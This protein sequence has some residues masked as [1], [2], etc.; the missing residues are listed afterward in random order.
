MSTTKHW[1]PEILKDKRVKY[2]LLILLWALIAFLLLLITKG[3]LG[4]H[5]KFLG[6]EV[7]A[8]NKIV[9]ADTGYFKIKDTVYTPTANDGRII[10]TPKSTKSK[11]AQSSKN[12]Q[13]NDSGKNEINENKGNNYGVIGGENNTVNNDF[14]V[15]Q[16]E[17]TP[18]VIKSITSKVPPNYIINFWLPGGDK[19]ALNYANKIAD[20]LYKLGYKK[21]EAGTWFDV[22]GNDKIEVKIKSDSMAAILV[23]PASNV[24]E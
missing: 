10:V 9:N 4:Y 12:V 24:K 15:K 6:I 17:P 2:P 1:L 8:P 7:N 13:I 23:S 18:D 11:S 21:F 5:V 3:F 16:R 14:S 20:E 22:R 19:E